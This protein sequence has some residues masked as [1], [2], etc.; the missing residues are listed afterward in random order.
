MSSHEIF[1]PGPDVLPTHI[2]ALADIL[3]ACV[4]AGAS[5]GFVQ[6]CTLEISRDFWQQK[7]F[8]SVRDGGRLMLLSR[9]DDRITGTVQLVTDMLP[10]QRHRCEV[11]KLLVHPDY[12]RQGIAKM[13]MV[14]LE[15]RALDLGKR[16][17]TLDTKT[18]DPAE[19]IYSAM[20][21][22]TAGSIPGY[23]RSPEGDCDDATTYMY[24]AL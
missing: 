11:S 5:L 14:D 10:S 21:Y 3:S 23:C 7:I 22:Q 6:P 15:Q 8:P 9:I 24:K 20:G 18:G 17:I 19:K 16:L 2:D 1:E 4:Q 12:R 13:L